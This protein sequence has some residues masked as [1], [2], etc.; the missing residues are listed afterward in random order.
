MSG[1]L[2][3]VRNSM[4]CEMPHITSTDFLKCAN[5]CIKFLFFLYCIVE[6]YVGNKRKYQDYKF[7][8]MQSIQIPERIGK[9]SV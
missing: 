7:E 6:R 9:L 5:S 2:A 4:S 8:Y 1:P 3:R